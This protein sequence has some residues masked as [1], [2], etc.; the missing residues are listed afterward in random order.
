MHKFGYARVSSKD[1]N[2]ARQISALKEAGIDEKSI[3]IDRQSGKDFDR[4]GYKKL[5]KKIQ[6]QDELY[7]K[8][9][10]RLGRN[11]GEIL[12]QWRFLTK[13]KKVNMVVLDFPLL[14]TRRSAGGVTGE[15]IADLVLQILSYVAQVEREN[16]HQRQLEGIK[17]AKKRGVR[18]G[19]PRLPVPDE[20]QEVADQVR[21]KK[22]SLREG[23]RILGISYTTL[24]NWMKEQERTE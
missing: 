15:F 14:D 2:L 5:V 9:I 20:F 11:Y 10:D 8:S 1:Q 19:R 17:E 7:I 22:I 4:P 13:V 23:G 6:E 18:F 12:E 24:R 3:F 16:T 21:K